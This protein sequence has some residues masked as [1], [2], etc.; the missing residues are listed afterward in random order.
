M[1]GHDSND[2]PPPDDERER[3][4]AEEERQVAEE[5]RHSGESHVKPRKP[6]GSK[7]RAL[8]LPPNRNA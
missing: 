3:R 4:R 2:A 7:K 8:A 5:L 1:H 6:D